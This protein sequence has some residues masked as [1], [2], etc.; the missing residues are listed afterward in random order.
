MS[1]GV[2]FNT[3]EAVA[4]PGMFIVYALM[5]GLGCALCWVLTPLDKVVRPDGNLV[6]VSTERPE[7]GPEIRGMIRLLRDWRVLAL[8]PAFIYSNWFYAYQFT[9][10]NSTLFTARTQGLNNVFYWSAEMLA[11]SAVGQF[12]DMQNLSKGTRAWTLLLGSSLAIAASWVWGFMSNSKYGLDDPTT[13]SLID[14]KQSDWWGP[15]IL[16]FFWGITDASF[17]TWCYWCMGQLEDS[18]ETLSRFSGVYKGFQSVGAAASWLLT[19]S[20]LTAGNQATLVVVIFAL[21]LPG[22]MV[23]CRAVGK[24]GI[25]VDDVDK[26]LQTDAA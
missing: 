14:F 16:Y 26:P 23:I 18:P 24:K 5:M 4:K 10:Y 7:V 3:D 25:S 21:S 22:A 20:N 15:L 6:E 12:L 13:V 1:F 2:N 11:A 9:C 19:T 17:Q 8:L